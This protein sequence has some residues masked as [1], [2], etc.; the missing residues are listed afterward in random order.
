MVL[1]K[2]QQAEDEQHQ[3]N[4]ENGGSSSGPESYLS[5]SFDILT[6]HSECKITQKKRNIT[7]L[8]KKYIPLPPP[9]PVP[10]RRNTLYLHSLQPLPLSLRWLIKTIN[11]RLRE[12]SKEIFF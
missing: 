1:H 5:V 8:P 9:G 7:L 2:H 3:H 12:W 6:T 11:P 10:S 4:A